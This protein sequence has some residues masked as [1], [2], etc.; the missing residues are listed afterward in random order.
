MAKTKRKGLADRIREQRK[1]SD[2]DRQ[3]EKDLITMVSNGAC[4]NEQ[5]PDE[6][7]ENET[8]PVGQRASG[9]LSHRASEH[10]PRPWPKP[11]VQRA[12][13]PQGHRASE[14]E[15]HRA[16]G[17]VLRKEPV[18]FEPDKKPKDLTMDQFRILHFIYFNRP[19]KVRS[20][21]GLG[22]GDLI[23]PTMSVTNVRN[24]MKSLE[25][26]GYI[27]KPFSV[28]NGISQGSS[29]RVNLEKCILLFG[30]SGLDETG[31]VSQWSSESQSHRATGPVP[32]SYSSSSVLYKTTTGA[33]DLSDP[34]LAYWAESGL[35][36]DKIKK[37][38]KEFKI[39]E[40]VIVDFL[41]WARFD[42]VD[43]R[44]EKSIKEDVQSW[45]YGALKKGGYSKPVNFK[46]HQQKQIEMEKAELEIRQAEIKELEK[47]RK[48]KQA[49]QVT[50]EFEQMMSDPE[51]AL[52]K[53]CLESLPG[54]QKKRYGNPST[55]Q[56]QAFERE[57][58]H[59]LIR[60]INNGPD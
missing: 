15:S 23:N 40:S 59:A 55:H 3:K 21:K 10:W 9:P 42:L 58:K 49:L 13:E 48:Q 57:M 54:I 30:K 33:I 38:A 39:S 11:E 51:G 20:K 24:R 52:Y 1:L 16:S 46:S 31:P 43:N 4:L 12:T 5:T 56:G 22:I 18:I 45:F 6:N 41:R 8:E 27:E 47:L 26:K 34:D 2:E 37:W 35:T 29:C 28:N 44:K 14:P 53:Q 60:I 50:L 19:F 36:D 17:P 25:K 7:G 32:R